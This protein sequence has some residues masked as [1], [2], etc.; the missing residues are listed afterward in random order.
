MHS[1]SVWWRS[2][3]IGRYL[4]Q[5]WTVLIF[6]YGR[7]GVRVRFWMLSLVSATLHCAWVRLDI[8]LRLYSAIWLWANAS[9]SIRHVFWSIH[10]ASELV[11]DVSWTSM[12]SLD[13]AAYIFDVYKPLTLVIE[14]RSIRSLWGQCLRILFWHL[15]IWSGSLFSDLYDFDF[16]LTF[17]YCGERTTFALLLHLTEF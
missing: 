4:H 10:Y 3:T 1:L 15:G 16:V 5:T 12:S 13:F 2:W 17:G 8:S 14:C 6:L 11:Y 9:K 7:R